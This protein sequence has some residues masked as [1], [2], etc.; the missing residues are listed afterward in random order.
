[1][2]RVKKSE[3]TLKSAG[4]ALLSAWGRPSLLRRCVGRKPASIPT[5]N[6]K[7]PPK[8]Q[9]RQNVWSSFL[10]ELLSGGTELQLAVE[11]AVAGFAVRC[12]PYSRSRG[13]LQVAVLPASPTSH[14]GR[15]CM[16]RRFIARACKPVTSCRRN[17]HMYV[18]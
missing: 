12:T 11:A 17:L 14:L 10:E 7:G 5:P 16:R 9:I 4:D 2:E 1:M 13:Q 3:K 15:C 18:V 6:Q 8:L